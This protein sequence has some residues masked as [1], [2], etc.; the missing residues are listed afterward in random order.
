VRWSPVRAAGKAARWP[1]RAAVR[2]FRPHGFI[3]LY[4]RIARP[5]LDPWKICVSPENFDAQLAVLRR[6]ADIVA[7]HELPA[8]VRARDRGRPVAAITFDDGY[9]DNLEHAAP[10]LA[11]R[12]APATVFVAT[13]SVDR[14]TFWWDR[15]AWVLLRPDRLPDRLELALPDGALS[16][17]NAGVRFG[18]TLDRAVRR[19]LHDSLWSRLRVLPDADRDGALNELAKWSGCDAEP[20]DAGR[21]MDSHE[22]R[23]LAGMQHMSVGAHSVS[24]TALPGLPREQ[25]ALEILDSIID[26]ERL[27]GTRPACF[28]YPHGRFD[29]ESADL[30]RAAGLSLACAGR[31]DLVW[32]G[33]PRYGLPRL[34]VHDW[35]GPLFERW[36]RWYW[37]P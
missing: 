8:A 36:L 9:V 31:Q 15:L 4:H 20:A 13:G 24:H 17:R 14:K 32:R 30:V 3:L 33:A 6:H 10:A 27:T 2:R 18:G 7:L 35:S 37:L 16:W 23:R 29:A 21:P 5:P 12:D 34:S 22:V 19:R 26:C 25:K 1:V 11:R 28:S